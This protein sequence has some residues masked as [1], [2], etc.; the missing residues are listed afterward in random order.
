V[1]YAA[2]RAATGRHA[3]RVERNAD[4]LPHE[5]F[6]WDTGWHFGEWLVPGDDI[7][8]LVGRLATDDHGIVATAYLHR[9]AHELSQLAALVGQDD[10]AC[11]Y[12][13]LA[14]DVL[15]AWRTEFI[16]AD[17]GVASDRQ[18]DLVRAVVFGLVPVDLV[19]RT[20]DD[21][22]A[23]VRSAGSHLGTGFLATPFLLPVL[24]DHG[25]LDL[26]YE[27][28]FQRTS[29]SWLSM[30]DRDATTIWEDWNGVGDDGSVTH[31]LNHYSK[32]AVIS[33][34]HRYTAGLR[35]TS[36]GWATVTISPQPGGGVTAASMSHDAPAGRIATAWQIADGVGTIEVTLPPGV[37]ADLALP[38]GRTDALTHGQH[39]RT[40]RAGQATGTP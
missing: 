32:G 40:W 33:F 2:R 34:L 24:A 38:D 10:V 23:L 28:L 26:A 9:S 21:L 15:D 8:N 11:T 3:T 31:S 27:V 35:P 5:Q 22:A 13:A 29:P 12:C 1:D 16:T 18:A 37:V 20:V 25:Y 6:V 19:Q 17:G 30:I 7:V 14:A 36:P 4:P 39:T